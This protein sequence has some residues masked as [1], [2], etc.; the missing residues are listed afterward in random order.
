MWQEVVAV[1]A[2]I[3]GCWRGGQLPELPELPELPQSEAVKW[4]DGVEGRCIRM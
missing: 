3:R 4:L 2:G 1:L